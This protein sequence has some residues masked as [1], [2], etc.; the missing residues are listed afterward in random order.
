[1][2]HFKITEKQAEAVLDMKLARLTKLDTDKLRKEL[3]AIIDQI[4]E[5]EKILNNKEHR[6]SI[7]IDKI[8]ELRNKY[9]DA[10]KTK[11]MNIAIP[12]KEKEERVIPDEEN[13]VVVTKNGDVKRIA[14]T[15]FKV[16]KRNTK[17]IKNYD[18][19]ILSS[20]AASTID[21]IMVFTNLGRVYKMSVFDL[22]EGTNAAKGT[23]FSSL[24]KFSAGEKV[25]ATTI[26]PSRT[27]A[28]Y[29]CFV[30][31]NGM[32]KKTTLEEYNSTS[33][34][35][36]GIIGIKIKEGDSI[37]E[38]LLTDKEEVVIGTKNGLGVR[39]TTDDIRPIGRVAMGIKGIKL[40]EGDEVVS[41]K[42]VEKDK[43]LLVASKD[44]YGKRIS[45]TEIPITSKGTKGVVITN[46]V[47]LAGLAF[48]NDDDA[49]LV[50]GD[51]S[52]VCIDVKD[53]PVLGKATKG[54][55]LIK[56]NDSI[57]SITKV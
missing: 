25:M 17:G 36:N 6:I 11:L 50:T 13:V 32:I 27:G 42:V 34:R 55:I 45:A 1:M 4:A 46:K 23:N 54:N 10:R 9:G 19:V 5:F 49:V 44:G 51:K 29:V 15:K 20:S 53:I 28:K 3:Q 43:L 7:L 16:Q 24:F 52:L 47:E 48:V 33:N 57:Y 31:K 21:N 41:A 38:V 18:G 40:N 30:T 37:A 12:K 2:S 35:A 56:G 26:I 22:P 8:T 39:Y 14:K